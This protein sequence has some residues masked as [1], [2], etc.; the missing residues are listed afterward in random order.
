MFLNTYSSSST[1]AAVT[2]AT[3][4]APGSGFSEFAFLGFIVLKSENI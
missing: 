4:D 3:E 2:A 1:Y